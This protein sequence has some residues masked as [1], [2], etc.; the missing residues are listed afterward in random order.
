MQL[1][2]EAGVFEQVVDAIRRERDYQERDW[3]ARPR[4]VAEWLLILEGELQE[5]KEAWVK[6]AGDRHALEEILQVA[7]VAVSCLVEHGVV[8]RAQPGGERTG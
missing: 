4:S 8:E 1:E 3:G 2:G 6:N 7:A 5:A